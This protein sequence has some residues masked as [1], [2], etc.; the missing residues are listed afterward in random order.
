MGRHVSRCS[1]CSPRSRGS[2]VTPRPCRP[3]SAFTGGPWPAW[4][5]LPVNPRCRTCKALWTRG[6][7]SSTRVTSDD[8]GDPTSTQARGLALGSSASRPRFGQARSDAARQRHEQ[9]RPRSRQSIGARQMQNVSEVGVSQGFA[10]KPGARVR[11]WHD[12][13]LG[14]DGRARVTGGLC[15]S[16]FRDMLR[17]TC[18][19]RLTGWTSATAS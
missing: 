19:Q 14:R 1:I 12:T 4:R 9:P 11:T 7:H 8:Q 10:E 18:V 5:S 15:T 16:G 2:W 6:V 17:I 13:Y 3:K